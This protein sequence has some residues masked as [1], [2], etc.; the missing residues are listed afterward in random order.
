[1]L[2]LI[3]P[4]SDA[5]RYSF[6]AQLAVLQTCPTVIRRTLKKGSTLLAAKILVISRLLH[7]N[8]AQAANAP[9]FVESLKNQ[10]ASLRRKLLHAIDK[11]FSRF[12]SDSQDV[13]ESMCAFSLATSSTPSD[14]LRHF[15][16]IRLESITR[17]V[18]E[19][20]NSQE[21]LPRALKLYVRTL[22]DTQSIFPKRLADA[23]VRLKARPLLQDQEIQA[24]AELN[25]DVHERWIADEVRN[26]TPWPRHDELS[27]PD[28]ERLLKAWAR[29][30]VKAFLDSTRDVLAAQED[31][32]AVLGMRREML[33]TWLS[34]SNRSLGVDP[35]TVL[36]DLRD[37]M[38][39]RLRALLTDRAT[40][41]SLVTADLSKRLETWNSNSGR[42]V[43]S[44]WDA[45]TTSIDTSNGAPTFKRAVIERSH[46][47]DHSLLSLITT[48]DQW[49]QSLGEA[50]A[51]IKEMKDTKWDDDLNGD[52]QDDDDDLESKQALL[53]EDDPRSLEDALK[54]ALTT[55]FAKLQKDAEALVSTTLS[56]SEDASSKAIL[57]VRAL[58]EVSQ[59]LGGLSTTNRR[60]ITS[61]AIFPASVTEPLHLSI[62]KVV[63]NSPISV[64]KS[65]MD[66]FAR[67]R[68][69][70]ARVLWEGTPPLPAQPSVGTFKFLNTLSQEMVARGGDLW[71]PGA[72]GV[73]K[74]EI[75]NEAAAVVGKCVDAI[76]DASAPGKE[77]DAEQDAE[78]EDNAADV[79]DDAAA[80]G[81]GDDKPPTEKKKK[82]EGPSAE[83]QKD[84]VTHLLF[85]VL[86]LQRAF[87]GQQQKSVEQQQQSPLAALEKRLQEAAGADGPTLE[88]LRKNAGDFWRK[89]YLLFALLS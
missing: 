61:S 75:S 60:T 51:V 88:R 55:A 33:E 72:V 59:R 30:A 29:Q 20:R 23:L 78:K 58:R 53:S 3:C 6:A 42:C 39:E 22:V 63:I 84:K 21:H 73:L 68:R 64:Y 19:G 56:G 13:L 40:R 31:P 43:T 7:K 69:A 11:H 81:D 38:N 76:E 62:S 82:A 67:S 57:L 44:L 54:E 4:G 79:A 18:E 85:D 66:K 83:V 1:M 45:S 24:I 41:L 12:N 25:L 49:A 50:Y 71:S 86:F 14:V 74:R 36:D 34:S 10:L 77:D 28:A 26:F 87:G 65:S 52:D 2:V 8:L 35:S 47:L 17:L 89:T 27:K 46:G 16:H 80:A 37:V 70:R 9:P 15:H 5:E 32:K 48:Y